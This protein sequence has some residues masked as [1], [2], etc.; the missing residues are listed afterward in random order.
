M[1]V[2]G[3]GGGVKEGG[4][5]EVWE[6]GGD[7]KMTRMA[8]VVERWWE[9]ANEGGSGNKQEK[10]PSFW[11][12]EDYI[13]NSRLN[14]KRLSA[15]TLFP[16]AT[17]TPSPK[18]MFICINLLLFIPLFCCCFVDFIAVTFFLMSLN[19]ICYFKRKTKINKPTFLIISFAFLCGSQ[20]F[21]L[22]C[23]HCT[24]I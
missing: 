19:C 2:S 6:A 14:Y 24:L 7:E 8:F 18:G 15:L 20:F 23:Q 5:G 1:W 16:L 9:V 10:Q 4:R 13:V 12:T 22:Q 21:C 17:A 3:S 11:Y